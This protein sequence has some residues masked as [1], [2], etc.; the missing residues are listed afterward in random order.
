MIGVSAAWLMLFVLVPFAIVAKISLS[1]PATARPP[2]RPLAPDT[3]DPRRW[4][5]FLSELGVESYRQL[6][7]DSL[8][9]EATLASVG[10][11]ALATAIVAPLGYAIAL[12]ISRAPAAW[13]PVLIALVVLPFWTSFVI[14]VYAWIAIL[15]TDGWLNGALLALGLIGEP[16][17]IL[18]TNAAILVGL[19]YGYLPFMILPVYAA[20]DRLDPTLVEAAADLGAPPLRRFWT[21]TFPLSL[22]GLAAGCLLCFIPMVG[23]YV[24]PELLG[25]ADTLML[26]RTLY[27]EFSANRDWPLAAAIA[28][29]LL[30]IL[31]VPIV[32]LREIE[33]RRIEAAA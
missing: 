30:A 22:P 10:L 4:I 26:G 1:Q 19:V 23:E 13:R 28:I 15:K 20:L 21:V 27:L 12:A 3:L 8:Y 7:S 9:L 29:V 31:I 11:A 2:Y 17:E 33:S 5:E 14:R 25:G 6:T 16:L 24:V 18:N 32:V